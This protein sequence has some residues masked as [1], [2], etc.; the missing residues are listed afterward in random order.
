[1][2]FLCCWGKRLRWPDDYFQLSLQLS[3]QRYIL[4][5]WRYF[6]VMSN[7]TANNLSLNITL[8]RSSTDNQLYPRTGS[9]FSAS[10][11]ITPPWSKFDKKDYKHLANDL[12]Q[13]L[14][15]KNNKK[16]TVG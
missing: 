7:G 11:S 12:F 13:Q 4:K 3:Y 1:M 9:E 5:N 14:I 2:G 10:L 6:F 16:N 8:N 15:K